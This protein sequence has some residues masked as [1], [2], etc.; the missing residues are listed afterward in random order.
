MLTALWS[1]TISFG[2][3][4][5][6]VVVYPATEDKRLAF[7]QFHRADYGRIRVQPVC[8]L[9]RTELERWDITRGYPLPDGSTV[10]IHDR[11]LETLPR[12]QART[13][14]I[15]SFVPVD[16]VQD[17]RRYRTPYYLAPQRAGA[18]AYR[19]LRDVMHRRGRAAVVRLAIAGDRERLATLVAR[20]D[21]ILL[22]TMY[23]HDEVRPAIPVRA[24]SVGPEEQ[25]AAAAL[26]EAMTE[27]ALRPDRHVD[28]YREQLQAIIAAKV[29]T[30]E[31]GRR[32]AGEILE[33]RIG[34]LMAA[35]TQSV[36]VAKRDRAEPRAGTAA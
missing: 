33:D 12:A 32:P 13:V 26:V 23:W 15:E 4:T 16:Q 6:P 2:L 17:V 29:E 10:L 9:D 35:L 8:E 1:G 22:R 7:H 20:D 31:V 21:V 18:H 36:A 5:I 19:L 3:V 25:A 14:A 24:A 11:D 30:R 28:R 34:D 27:P